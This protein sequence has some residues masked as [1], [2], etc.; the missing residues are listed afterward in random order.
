MSAISVNE[1]SFAL[2]ASQELLKVSARPDMIFSSSLAIQKLARHI[3]QKNVRDEQVY[4]THDNTE[5]KARFSPV[6]KLLNLSVNGVD[7]TNCRPKPFWKIATTIV[8]IA[9]VCL[10]IAL[11]GVFLLPYKE[12]VM[13]V[14]C[15][16]ESLC[17]ENGG[18]F[19]R[20]PFYSLLSLAES[21]CSQGGEVV[22]QAFKCYGKTL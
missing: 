7:R 5:I 4:F 12:C 17:Y 16:T 15:C 14:K 1:H 18:T 19:S 10:G 21:L 3:L 9:T 22:N 8:S 6:G 13:N 11:A 2:T 20:V